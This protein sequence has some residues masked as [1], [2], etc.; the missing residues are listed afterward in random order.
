MLLYE[1]WRVA[2][3]PLLGVTDHL[4]QRVHAL[5]ARPDR[6]GCEI[7]GVFIL[8][9]NQSFVSPPSLVSKVDDSVVLGSEQ[10]NAWQVMSLPARPAYSILKSLAPQTT[11]R[12]R[13]SVLLRILPCWSSSLAAYT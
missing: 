7:A 5:Q 3:R 8:Q 11:G 10:H 1:V 2:G 13:K 9:A 4:T 6:H 12:P